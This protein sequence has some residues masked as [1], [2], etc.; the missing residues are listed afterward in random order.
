MFLPGQM[1][2]FVA[3]WADAALF[4]VAVISTQA[5]EARAKIFVSWH[6]LIRE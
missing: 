2:P 5:P 4:W 1:A 3:A 6:C